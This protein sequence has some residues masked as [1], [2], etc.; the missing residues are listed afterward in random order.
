MI[1]VSFQI[2]HKNRI[3]FKDLAGLLHNQIGDEANLELEDIAEWFTISNTYLL[4]NNI[5]I[6]IC[7]LEFAP[8]ELRDFQ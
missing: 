4:P 1:N 2:Q 5:V 6:S 7:N 8:S 3:T